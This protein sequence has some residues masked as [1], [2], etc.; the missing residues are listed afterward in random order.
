[1]TFPGGARPEGQRRRGG[2]E[3][4]GHRAA[5]ARAEQR[6]RARGRLVRSRGRGA[7][8]TAGKPVP[9]CGARRGRGAAGGGGS[10]CHFLARGGSA[11]AR[12]HLGDLHVE[13][14]AG[15]GLRERPGL[16]PRPK[17]TFVA[18]LVL[19]CGKAVKGFRAFRWFLELC[20]SLL[21]GGFVYVLSCDCV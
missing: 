16:T 9:L 17:V 11:P 19:S 21:A 13:P 14:V 20:S 1:M 6:P 18:G 8:G 2:Y 5:A 7:R 3:W 10:W 15:R 4:G 12:R